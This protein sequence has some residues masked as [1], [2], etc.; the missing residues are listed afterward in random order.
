MQKFN[1]NKNSMKIFNNNVDVDNKVISNLIETNNN[2]M[3]LS[4]CLDEAIRPLFSILS[5][6]SEY[7]QI[8]RE[9]NS[10]LMYFLCT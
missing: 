1:N 10:K 4:R 3:Y 5:K 2:S 9:K 8:F 6:M 7:V